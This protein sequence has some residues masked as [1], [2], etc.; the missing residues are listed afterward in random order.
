MCLLMHIY[1][2]KIY[3]HQLGPFKL[4]KTVLKYFNV[5]KGLFPVLN[6]YLKGSHNTRATQPSIIAYDKLKDRICNKLASEY[7]LIY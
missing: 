1:Y 6:R 4:I 7:N 5:L 2:F 3:F